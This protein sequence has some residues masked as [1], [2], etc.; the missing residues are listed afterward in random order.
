LLIIYLLKLLHKKEQSHKVMTIYI[1]NQFNRFEFAE[2][3]YS[4]IMDYKGWYNINT[5]SSYEHFAGGVFMR[6]D[7]DNAGNYIPAN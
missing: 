2:Q 6:N 3:I 7:R 1:P 4:M 5:P